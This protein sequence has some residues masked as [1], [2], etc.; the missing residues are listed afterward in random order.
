[1]ALLLVFGLGFSAADAYIR[2]RINNKNLEW[3][4]P[5]VTW[6][7]NSTGSDNIADGSH[8]PAIEHAFQEWEDVAG[9]DIDFTRGS[10]TTDVAPGGG[11]HIVAF[12][13]D[14]TSG[15]FPGGSG[16][17]AITPISYN[18]STGAITDAD[19]LFNGSQFTFSTDGTPGTFDVQDVLTH[20]IG[21]FIGLDHSPQV[22]GTM[23][24]YV[25]TTQWLH[26]SLT[27]DE[28]AGAVAVATG[29]NQTRLTGT[30]RRSSSGSKIAGAIVSAIRASDG[31]LM[32]MAVTNNNGIF[33]IRGMPA[34]DYWVH[35]TPLEGG[36]TTAN[37]TGNGTIETDFAAEFYGGF[38]S[39]TAH[40]LGVGGDVDCGNLDLD[41]DIAMKDNA[42]AAVLLKRGQSVVV[43]IFGSG[44]TASQM[45]MLVKTSALTVTN[46]TSNTSFVRG[47]ITATGGAGYG[48]YDIYLRNPGGDLEVAS[49]VIDVI[50][51]T[52]TITGLDTNTGSIVGGESVVVSGTNF[53]PGSYVLFGGVEAASV[54]Y[55]DS[56]TLNVTTPVATPGLVDLSVHGPDGQQARSDDAFTF[57]GAPV[58]TAMIPTAGQDTGGTRL[59]ITGNNFSAQTQVLLDGQSAA[60]TFMSAQVL[61][62]LTPAHA[63]GSVD[64]V[65]RNVGSPDNL[66]ADAFTYVASPD[67]RIT[68]FTPSSGPKA[69]GTLVRITG[70]SLSDIQSVKFGVDPVSGQ[71]GKLANLVDLISSTQVEAQT[72]S[73][74]TPGNFGLLLTTSSGQGT[75]SSG[76]T[77]EG[78]G[79]GGSGASLAGGGC[80]ADLDRQGPVDYRAEIP[81]WISLFGGFWLLRR[82]LRRKPASAHLPVE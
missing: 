66:Q 18:T 57:T 31:R 30:I 49:G 62:V 73:N 9:S 56:N 7:L 35:A 51:D 8:I 46:V 53:Q 41:D 17:V 26:R 33:T 75:L 19:I 72:G 80:S 47:T 2:I 60:T 43:T 34:A 24:P 69:G 12:D 11:S 70:I 76:F 61:Q 29:A 21:H 54:T 20:E 6:R 4:N 78:G 42:N 65:I 74:A 67:P 40:T 39:P 68:S 77:F 44:F 64:M 32:G 36:M 10:D 28:G 81:G 5:N 27:A 22:S 48:S 82:H 1:M 3:S 25:S 15:Y 14:N 79:D 50:P 13:E 38:A 16:I 71:G 55:V 59:Y 52:P 58:F 63:T 45:S 23:W 37:L